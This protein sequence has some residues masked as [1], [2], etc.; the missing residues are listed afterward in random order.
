MFILVKTLYMKKLILSALGL[1]FTLTSCATIF[2]GTSDQVNFTSEPAGATVHLK[3]KELC[4]TPCTAKVNRSVAKQEF[5]F[6]LDGYQD[7]P[8]LHSKTFNPV[9]LL[10]IAVGGVI[11]LGIDVATGS[12]LKP[13]AKDYSATMVSK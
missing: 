1:C 10:N 9:T 12:L 11:G 6:K 3:D 8:V 5:I 2:T 13:K 7:Q 4:T